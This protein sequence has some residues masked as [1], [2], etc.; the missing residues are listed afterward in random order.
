MAAPRLGRSAAL[1][2]AVAVC[3][4]PVASIIGLILF[5]WFSDEKKAAA[6]VSSTPR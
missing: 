3:F 1:W 5:E 4:A 6:S 2:G